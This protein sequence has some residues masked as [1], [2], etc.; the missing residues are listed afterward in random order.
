MKCPKCK[1]EFEDELHLKDKIVY[2][3]KECGLWTYKNNMID[4]CKY[5]CPK[6]RGNYKYPIKT[7]GNDVL[8]ECETHGKWK[9]NFLR[10]FSF[11]RLCSIVARKPN[12]DPSFYTKPELKIKRILDKLGLEENKDYYHNKRIK[13]KKGKYY[14]P[15]FLILKDDKRE[16]I[17][18]SPR[19]W[20][21]R[22]NR[23]DEGKKNYFLN[24]NYEY[25]SLSDK[26]M[27]DWE[28]IVRN[29]LL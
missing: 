17:E 11:R 28:D 13:V 4:V 22:W 27:P 3:C 10:S 25:L 2:L 21:S 7:I 12:K 23:D 18:C 16:V 29:E 8:C 20:H 5:P 24:K 19:I 15:D 1:I 6:C 9:T 26:T 14:Y